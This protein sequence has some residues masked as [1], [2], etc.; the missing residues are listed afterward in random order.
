M[1]E[2]L[3]LAKVS[4]LSPPILFFLLGAAAGTLRSDLT[5]PETVGKALALYLMMAIGFKG[6]ASLNGEG[7]DV[8]ALATIGVGLALGFVLPVVAFTLL[9]KLSDLD[10]PTK[11][12]VS[13]HYGSVSVV[14]FVT[15]VAFLDL[16]QVK[17]EAWLVAV[18]A[19]METPAIITGLLLAHRRSGDKRICNTRFFNDT[20]L[21]RA[22]FLNGSVVI[23]LGSFV[24]GWITGEAGLLTVAPFL[25]DPFTGVLCLFLLDMGL[26][27][28]R[29]LQ[30]GAKLRSSL[31][32]FAL[33]MPVV[34]AA[35][36]LVGALIVN[37]SLGGTLLLMVLAASASYI[38]VPAAM[39]VALPQANAGIYL[40]LSLAITF[41]FNIIVGIPIY[42][43]LCRFLIAD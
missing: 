18:M 8:S 30:Q 16:E 10:R 32:A 14:T 34:G 1:T 20:H 23:L 28:S 26:M 9:R 29:Q 22:V 35:L 39:R 2:V 40:P 19:L 36:G 3:L 42:F 17:Y 5:F 4:I 41:P 6:G 13:A 38:A 43:T 24:I 12:A 33:L 21:A 15:A 25:I 11:A 7:F 37:L 27:T 31:I